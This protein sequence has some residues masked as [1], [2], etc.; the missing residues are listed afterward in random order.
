MRGW[1]SIIV[2]VHHH[3]VGWN[4]IFLDSTFIAAINGLDF[5][6]VDRGDERA[7][8]LLGSI[9]RPPVYNLPIYTTFSST[10]YLRQETNVEE[11]SLVWSPPWSPTAPTPS[12]THHLPHRVPT[13]KVWMKSIRGTGQKRNKPT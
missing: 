5:Y 2:W 3:S 11:I 12:T 9:R 4:I 6:P 10:L 13:K 7:I 8:D 1:N